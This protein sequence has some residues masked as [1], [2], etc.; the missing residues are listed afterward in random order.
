M[1]ATHAIAVVALLAS[2]AAAAQQ[3]APPEPSGP[4]ITVTEK[5]PQAADKIV[6]KSLST[7][8]MISKRMC[9]PKSEWAKA[10]SASRDALRGMQDWQRVRCNFGTRC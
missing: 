10:E 3:A 1:L 4:T 7:G 5:K 6:C 2:A 8:T 9:M